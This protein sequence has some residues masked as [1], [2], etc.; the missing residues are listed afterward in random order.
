MTRGEQIEALSKLTTTLYSLG[1]A[2]SGATR[3]FA[4]AARGAEVLT[5]SALSLSAEG[6]LVLERVAVP[7]GRAAAALSG[8][9]GAIVVL[10]RANTAA[11]GGQPPPAQGPGQWGPAHD[12]PKKWFA[13]SGATQ[14]VEQAR[15]QFIAANGV[16]IRWHVAEK[17]AADAIRKLLAGGSVKGIEIV[18]TPALQ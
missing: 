4:S 17:K 18:H 13:P 2:G 14:L 15:R 3:T 12:A 8:G 10:Q 1:A 11:R 7:V 5:V 16:P 9:P 6:A